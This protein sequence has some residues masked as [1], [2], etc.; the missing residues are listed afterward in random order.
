MK[1]AVLPFFYWHIFPNPGK[2]FFSFLGYTD[3][4]MKVKGYREN[5]KHLTANLFLLLSIGLYIF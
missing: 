3:I 5:T 4:C 1:Y 2:K